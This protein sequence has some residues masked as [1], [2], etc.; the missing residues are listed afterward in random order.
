MKKQLRQARQAVYP[1]WWKILDKY[2]PRM[3]ELDPGCEL[4]V[5]EK[6]ATLRL[7]PYSISNGR[8]WEDF[9]EIG[10]E[11]EWE[12]GHTCEM[13]GAEGSIR[14]DGIWMKTLC[15]R[16]VALGP[17]GRARESDRTLLRYYHDLMKQLAGDMAEFELT[18][19]DEKHIRYL[20]NHPEEEDAIL[21]E[22]VE[23]HRGYCHEEG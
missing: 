16:C 2:I 3:L 20:A 8:S 19:D 18:E 10:M 5:K 9:Y 14:D 1:G 15:D 11:A 13:C 23:K 6:Y 21:Q 4:M 7:R 12:S 22:L 17:K